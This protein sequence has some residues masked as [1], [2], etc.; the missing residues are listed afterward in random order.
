[1]AK[2]AAAVA[3]IHPPCWPAKGQPA[4][5]TLRENSASAKKARA[6]T[7]PTNH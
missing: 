1:M 5:A 6:S 4:M 3:A 2:E 7:N